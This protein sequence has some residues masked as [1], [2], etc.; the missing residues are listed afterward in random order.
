MVQ[1]ALSP[2][3][4]FLESAQVGM[5]V[6]DLDQ[7]RIGKVMDIYVSD[8]T[9]EGELKAVESGL[10]DL[11]DEARESLLRFGFITIGNGFLRAMR[12]ICYATRDQ[13]LYVDDRTVYLNVGKDSLVKAAGTA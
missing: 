3:Y 5:N 7:C 2:D 13:I 4:E 1:E 10:A 6:Y 11:H 9:L 8:N 12:A